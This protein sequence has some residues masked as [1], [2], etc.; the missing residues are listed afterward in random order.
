M[1]KKKEEERIRERIRLE[2][3]KNVT[4][5]DSKLKSASLPE[6]Y[7]SSDSGDSGY[8]GDSGEETKPRKIKRRDA[9]VEAEPVVKESKNSAK[10]ALK[11]AAKASRKK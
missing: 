11:N 2:Q 4:Y 10:K 7:A 3:A 6:Y 8:S 1:L 9:K 5:T